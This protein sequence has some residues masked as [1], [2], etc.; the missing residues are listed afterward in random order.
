VI[1][2]RLRARKGYRYCFF[3]AMLIKSRN[4]NVLIAKVIHLSEAWRAAIILLFLLNLCFFPCISG[5]KTFLESS[6]D[7]PSILFRGAW[8]GDAENPRFLKVLDPGAPAWHQEALLKLIQHQYFAE[9]NFPL[10]NPSQGYG[11]PLAANMQ[12]QPFYPL[13]LALSL[14]VTPKTYN[15]FIV[16]RLFFAGFFAY[17]YARLFLSFFA[18]VAAGIGC[19]LAGYYILFITMSHLSV[20][21]LLPLGLLA[22]EHVL[23]KRTFRSIVF[24]ATMI[25]LVLVGGMPESAL[26]LF[27]FVYA[28]WLYRLTTDPVL[29]PAWIQSTATIAVSTVIGLC[30]SMFLLLPFYEYMRNSSNSHTSRLMVGLLHDKFDLSA[31]TYILPLLY[32]LPYSN[33]VDVTGTLNRNYIGVVSVFLVLV[34]C[35]ALVRTLSSEPVVLKQLTCFFLCYA[36]FIV[37]KRYGVEPI[38]HIGVL[39]LYS[40]VEFRKYGEPILS[41]CVAMLSAIGME[42]LIR[43][44]ISSTHQVS[45]LAFTVFLAIGALYPSWTMVSRAIRH[46]RPLTPSTRAIMLAALLL[47]SIAVLIGL[48]GRISASTRTGR[49]R[50]PQLVSIYL[51]TLIGIQACWSYIIPAYYIYSPPPDRS[52]NPYKGAPFVQFLKNKTGSYDRMFGRNGVLV[53]NWASTFGLYD[54][55]DL[56][57]MYYWK[58]F[59]FLDNFFP[60]YQTMAPELE[61]CFRGLGS[62]D[63]ADPLERR[64]LQLSSV[65]FIAT[66][67]AFA[68]PDPTVEKILKQNQGHLIP[69]K[70]IN[71]GHA[72]F[73]LDGKARSGL[74]EHPPYFRLPYRVT[75]GS[76]EKEIFHFSYAVNPQVYNLAGDGVGFRLEVRD[77]SDKITSLF[78]RYIDPKHNL[79]ERRWMQGS[80]DL[81]SY[82]DQQVD[83]LFSTDPGPKGDTSYDWA[84]W[85][86]LHFDWEPPVAEE[87]SFKP[88]YDGAARVFEYDDVLPR[89]ALYFHDDVMKNSSDVLRRLADPSLDI[90]QSVVLSSSDLNKNELQTLSDVNR[91]APRRVSRAK[92]TSYESQVVSIEASLDQPGILMLN[93]T[94]YPGWI[95]YIDNRPARWFAADY[96]FRGVLL[97]PGRHSVRFEYRPTS[98]Y[99]GAAISA[100][101]LAVLAVV[102]LCVW[103]Q[104]GTLARA[105]TAY[106]K[107]AW[108]IAE[109]FRGS[110]PD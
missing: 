77:Q 86:D 31:G 90:F 36:I 74:A 33:T 106:Q 95:A 11:Q 37:L 68:M 87:H 88:V 105:E 49:F 104:I 98:F 12:S 72:D 5:K 45:C 53:P 97:E 70:E 102:S 27:T 108:V 100:A 24:F 50:A 101:T 99:V 8:A 63:F 21:V 56:D 26:L 54:I 14:R 107:T 32:G 4:S 22:A 23:R 73:V 75:I 55:R 15:W 40:L 38:N 71:I 58:Y 28:Y 76:H 79:E 57:A 2:A 9:K 17:W 66:E 13:M 93:D 20:E 94:A 29:R 52:N 35:A 96:L 82:R 6:R 80:I 109:W 59:P 1:G 48:S 7:A 3:E 62:Y 10:W 110:A 25:V 43:R 84:A 83:L 51:L 78:S 64:L 81:S 46:S 103:L 61:S 34:A 41:I 47:C 85:S 18:A 19:M 30:L 16:L 65:R 39:P 42:W 89:A 91:A 69:G 60:G 92:I 67:R 44:G